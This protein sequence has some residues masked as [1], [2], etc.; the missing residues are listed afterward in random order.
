[1]P[2]KRET[3]YVAKGDGGWIV[4]TDVGE[5]QLGPYID[6]DHAV[7]MALTFAKAARPSQV[8]VQNTF[9]GWWTEHVFEEPPPAPPPA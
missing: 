2:A 7:L 6:K 9:G 4:K 1:M 3:F 8:K 5:D